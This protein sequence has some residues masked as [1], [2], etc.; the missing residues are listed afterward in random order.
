[1]RY[2]LR[3]LLLALALAPPILAGACVLPKKGME[4]YRQWQFDQ[5]AELIRTTV[6]GVSGELTDTTDNLAG[7]NNG[8]NESSLGQ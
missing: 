5:L 1:M 2:N 4:R 6:R 8:T 7:N 3:T